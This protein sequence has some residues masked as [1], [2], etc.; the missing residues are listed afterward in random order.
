MTK[1]DPPSGISDDV[2]SDPTMLSMGTL[3]IRTWNEPDQTPGFRARLT[4]SQAPDAE[5]SS[6]STADPDEVLSVVRQWLS[7]RSAPPTE[8]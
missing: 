6:I 8:M 7:T 4:Y 1:D 3:V 2:P 5:P